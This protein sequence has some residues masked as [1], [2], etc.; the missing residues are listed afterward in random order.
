M[1]RLITWERAGPLGESIGQSDGKGWE[2]D[3]KSRHLQGCSPRLCRLRTNE[4]APVSK[5]WMYW[6]HAGDVGLVNWCSLLT[7]MLKF[8][9]HLQWLLWERN[10]IRTR[11]SVNRCAV[12]RD[13]SWK[14]AMYRDC[15]QEVYEWHMWTGVESVHV[16]C[17]RFPL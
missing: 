1:L 16:V 6:S 15:P 4:L 9:W 10:W 2:C 5:Y 11:R 17:I 13:D 3:V 7:T 8:S 12:D 14:V